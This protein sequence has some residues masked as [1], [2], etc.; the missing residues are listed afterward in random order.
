[1]PISKCV[2]KLIDISEGKIN[3]S[4]AEKLLKDADR[5]AKKIQKKEGVSK[6]IAV[7]KAVAQR[8]KDVKK[9]LE[10]Q[11]I[12]K[13]RNIVIQ[14]NN[15]N[16]L[17]NFL[18][19]GLSVKDAINSWLFGITS[20]IAGTRDSIAMRADSETNGYISR[21]L[22]DLQEKNLYD[23]FQSTLLS[24]EIQK[25][26][27]A[28]SIKDKSKQIF[29]GSIEAREIAEIIHKM[30]DDIKSR[31]NNAGADIDDIQGFIVSQTHDS[32]K[33]F[34]IGKNPKQTWIDFIKPK[35]D[36]DKSFEGNYDDIDDA[37]GK[38]YEAI[39]TGIRKQS[40]E[41]KE[42]KLFQF[43]GIANLAQKLS[44]KRK[45]I[46]KSADDFIAYNDVYGMRSFNESITNTVDT[47]G[48]NVALLEDQGT[49]PNAMMKQSVRKFLERNRDRLATKGESV[50]LNFIETAIDLITAEPDRTS[51]PKLTN[52]V[53]NIKA[54]NMVRLMGGT[55]ISSI[56]NVAFKAIAYQYNGK[57]LLGSYGQYF[58]D[59]FNY[60]FKSTEDKIKFA[61]LTG[62][63][64]EQYVGN[65]KGRLADSKTFASKASKVVNMFMKINGMQW[66]D[67]TDKISMGMTLA[68]DLG[69]SKNLTFDK[70]DADTQRNF[71][72]MNITPEDW[73]KMRLSV[74]TLEDDGRDYLFSD[75]I[76]DIKLSN[77]LRAYYI[78]SVRYA[79]PEQTTSTKARM[80]FGTRRGTPMG[81]FLQLVLQFK[82]FSVA[83]A[84][85]V[86]GR[87]L[88]ANGKPNMAS[89][90]ML[91]QIVL[92]STIMGYI[93]MTAK[94]F[95]KGLTPR[96]PYDPKTI[97]A[98]LV[99]GGG[100]G[101]LGDVFFAQQDGMSK[102][103]LGIAAGPTF[104]VIDDFA[105]IYQD[106]ISGN[107]ASARALQRGTVLIPGQNLFY[108][109]PIKQSMIISA[110]E[111]LNP[112]SFG[113]MERNLKREKNQEF[114]INPQWASQ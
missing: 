38:A 103:L 7:E 89:V 66:L 113:R 59:M 93:A 28:L 58:S 23:A 105:K 53:N 49:N 18:E 97:L 69:L 42:S 44:Q 65:L 100:L 15:L 96:D 47:Q 62:V 56:T 78:D 9:S 37:L 110:Q 11:K 91:G 32:D 95:I 2:K 1:M 26:L 64:V 35:L 99:Q 6:D 29:S 67:S 73:D 10:K 25:D 45:L 55:V 12:Q 57:S 72:V 112:G 40:P 68:H 5:L 85:R 54:W 13:L 22:R 14:E 31:L 51:N 27:W 70:L 75:D 8:I 71:R 16:K 86:F 92:S 79:I 19:S 34:S 20:P 46:F 50:N 114:F 3:A 52:A 87:A 108:L 98:S 104:G 109:T 33:M 83:L 94:D 24:K 81:E 4:D 80:A 76:E 82:G 43:E 21:L 88:Y 60:G 90:A 84:E 102:G 107:D 63:Y 39:V 111:A 101:I 36:L 30:Y 17:D 74:R 77:K 41:P 106:A 61:R 48:R